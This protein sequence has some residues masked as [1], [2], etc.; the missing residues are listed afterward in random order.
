MNTSCLWWLLRTKLPKSFVLLTTSVNN[1]T[2]RHSIW[3]LLTMS[4]LS[5]YASPHCSPHK[6]RPH[7]PR[8]GLAYIIDE[9]Q[10]HLASWAATITLRHG[11]TLQLYKNLIIGIS[12]PFPCISGKITRIHYISVLKHLYSE[13]I[14]NCA[15]LR[16]EGFLFNFALQYVNI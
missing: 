11:L 2:S 13:G 15:H 8:K 7:R 1:M 5:R 6:F 16:D 14:A 10:K 9:I 3:V 12:G 4:S